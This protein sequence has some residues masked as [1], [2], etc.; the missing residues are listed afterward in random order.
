ML[1]KAL[2]CYR[3]RMPFCG[4]R[5]SQRIAGGMR[6]REGILVHARADRADGRPIE[7]WG[8]IAPY[9]GRSRESLSEAEDGL[10]ELLARLV[11]EEVPASWSA[12]CRWHPARSAPASVAFG[13][14]SA[15]ISLGALAAGMSSASWIETR[16]RKTVV[17][18]ALLDATS[19]S[20]SREAEDR[21]AEGYT[22]FKVKVG[23]GRPDAVRSLVKGLRKIVGADAEIRLDAN[24]SWSYGDA[25]D[26]LAAIAEMGVSYVEEPLRDAARLEELAGTAAVPIAVDET[27]EEWARETERIWFG[28]GPRTTPR[29]TPMPSSRLPGLAGIRFAVLK[30]TLLGGVIRTMEL[31]ADLHA[32]GLTPV[33]SAAFETEIGIRVLRTLAAAVPGEGTAAGVDTIRY[34]A[35]DFLAGTLGAAPIWRMSAAEEKPPEVIVDRL[36]Y[37]F[38]RTNSGRVN[39]P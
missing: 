25:V 24:R 18:N 30:P 22:A 34:V 27:L 38:G 9:P 37:R 26:I 17:A 4:D 8:E 39:R 32:I 6:I 3:Y 13:I 16:A 15:L 31:A 33:I 5:A 21:A 1:L 2:D 28:K 11:G 10:R 19:E 29:S 23:P 36:E 35:P 14:E 12:L 20:I 7:S